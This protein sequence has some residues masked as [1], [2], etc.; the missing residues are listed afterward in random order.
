MV[1][2]KD[3]QLAG[4]IVLTYSGNCSPDL[5]NF[6]NHPVLESGDEHVQEFNINGAYS[7]STHS[8]TMKK[9]LIILFSLS[10]GYVNAQN[11]KVEEDASRRLALKEE[12]SQN[13]KLQEGT[14]LRIALKEEINSKTAQVGDFVA[15]EV[16]DD[17]DV[18][19]VIVITAGTPL[20][21][22]ITEAS[23][24]KMMGKA[25][26]I[27]FIVTFT[28]SVDG[29]NIRLR[30]SNK[31]FSGT[32]KQGGIIAAAVI[33]NPLVLLLKGKNIT[34]KKGQNF[35]AYIDKDYVIQVK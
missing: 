8:F 32:N 22:E 33:V 29:Q 10:L 15:L 24:A 12:T 5:E 23:K 20:K 28:R 26:K 1:S 16:I 30:T 3:P 25:G 6:R 4:E 31:S 21:G 35:S 9:Y 13:M 17:V 7:K 2:I 11:T 14:S 19:G 18:N 34:L 27:D